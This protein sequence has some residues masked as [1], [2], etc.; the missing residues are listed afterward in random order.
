MWST[1]VELNVSGTRRLG[2]LVILEKHG[3]I[4]VLLCGNVGKFVHS[5]NVYVATDSGKYLC[6]N[7]FRSKIAVWLNAGERSLNDVELN[8]SA[9]E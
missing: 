8:G 7:N 4:A 3:L 9:G 5:V 1:F 6:M 2:S